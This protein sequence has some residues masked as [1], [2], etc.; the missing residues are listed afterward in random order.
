MKAKN[1]FYLLEGVSNEDKKI[2]RYH[3]KYNNSLVWRETLR[4]AKADWY[5][6]FLNKQDNAKGLIEMN[7]L[8][9]IKKYNKEIIN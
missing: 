5:R 4:E 1:K 9:E 7:E 2:Y 6:W 3:N 8:D